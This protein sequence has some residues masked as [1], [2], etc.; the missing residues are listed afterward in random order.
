MPWAR[1]GEATSR[2]DV[3]VAPVERKTPPWV[4]AWME[5]AGHPCT[6]DHSMAGG[7]PGL[8]REGG[9]SWAPGL[10]ESSG[11]EELLAGGPALGPRGPCVHQE[12]QSEGADRRARPCGH[13]SHLGRCASSLLSQI[14]VRLAAQAPRAEAG[15]RT[16]QPRGAGRPAGQGARAGPGGRNGA[17]S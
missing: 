3:H 9:R 4:P 5:G 10:G 16:G 13:H 2:L 15:Q 8:P 11:G 17:W 6:G 1:P 14:Q 7:G 12:A